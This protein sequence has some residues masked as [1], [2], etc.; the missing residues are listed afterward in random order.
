MTIT[1]RPA[2]T[3]DAA[4]LSTIGEA[5]FIE[6]FG[7]DG[8][9]IPYPAAELAAW[10]PEAYGAAKF[11]GR[12]A[13]ADHGVWIAEDAAGHAI[14][15]ATAGPCGL[16]HP[17]AGDGGEL[18]QLY[19]TRAGQ[20]TGTGARLFDI[21]TGWLEAQGHRQLWLGVWSGNLKAQAFYRRRGFDKVGDYLFP[22]GAWRDEEY[23]FRRG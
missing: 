22:V 23:I 13:S 9:A 6:T 1:I 16:P 3:G 19:V 14:G 5:T 8:F 7:P 12:I 10:L 4:T 2:V 15:Y 20:G 11:A 18:Y 21:A 17:E